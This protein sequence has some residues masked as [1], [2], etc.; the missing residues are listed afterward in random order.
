M[1]F[2]PAGD[3][4]RL[5]I[6]EHSREVVVHL[7][8][9]LRSELERAKA[10][11]PGELAPHMKRLFPTAYHND[12]AHD[13]EYRRLTHGDLADAHLRAIDD[14]VI[15]LQPNRVFNI[16]ELER[17]VRAINAMRL[18]L[19]T[20]LDV[21]EDG[22]GK[23]ESQ[24]DALGGERGNGKGDSDGDSA[25]DRETD[26]ASLQREV[27]DYLGWLLYSSLDQLRMP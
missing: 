4:F 19:G 25:D 16:A 12:A 21:S 15:L 3:G 13:D 27:Y 20:V 10:V 26:P 11:A 5:V 6:D 22:E 8:G 18:V 2:E 9:E 17:F 23:R 1:T 24:D 14:A 7:L